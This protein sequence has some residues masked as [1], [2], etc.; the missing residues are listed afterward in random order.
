MR[1]GRGREV[2]EFPVNQELLTKRYTEEAVKWIRAAWSPDA[3]DAEEDPE[4]EVDGEGP[5]DEKPGEVSG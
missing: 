4:G 3:L 1:G 5:D 2:V